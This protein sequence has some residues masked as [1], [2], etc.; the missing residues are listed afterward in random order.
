MSDSERG[1]ALMALPPEQRAAFLASLAPEERDAL[2]GHWPYWAR[3][4]QVAP[5][6]DWRT[7][8][9]CA[10]RGFGKTR[11]GAEWVRQVAGDFPEAHIA[12]V[13]SSIG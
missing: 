7:W 1:A 9:I 3:E 12:L 6:R 4:E 10:G 2:A 8:L 13:G 11:A 5:A